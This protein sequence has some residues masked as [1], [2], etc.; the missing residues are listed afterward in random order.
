M[1]KQNKLKCQR[2]FF[3]KRAIIG[4]QVIPRALLCFFLET[5]GPPEGMEPVPCTWASWGAQG[6]LYPRSSEKLNKQAALWWKLPSPTRPD[7]GKLAN[8]NLPV[9]IE[10]GLPLAK[11]KL[12]SSETRL[13][14]SDRHV[15]KRKPFGVICPHLPF[16]RG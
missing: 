2:K 7:G 3:V 11:E 9:G 8:H 14:V 1:R 15:V 4:F 5:W 16:R 10:K 12:F 13:C 6:L